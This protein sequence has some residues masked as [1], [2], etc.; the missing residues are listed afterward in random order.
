MDVRPVISG[1][2][3]SLYLAKYLMKGAFG[4]QRES[5]EATGFK[6]RWSRTRG[7]PWPR[8]TLRGSEQEQFQSYEF[9][10]R[11]V[12]YEQMENIL[13]KSRGIKSLDIVSTE[14]FMA[15]GKKSDNKRR[16]EKLEKMM[17]GIP[18]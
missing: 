1:K 13:A 2:G 14:S 15:I 17:G 7:W 6:R 18:E 11:G 8:V 16:I 9:I 4:E 3:V 10:A 5:L 12:L